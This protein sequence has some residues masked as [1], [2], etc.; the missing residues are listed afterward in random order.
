VGRRVVAFAEVIG[1]EGRH[2]DF[3]VYAMDGAEEIGRGTHQRAVIDLARF[4]ERLAAKF[5]EPT[6]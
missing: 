4:S 5:T 2:V 6:G 3:Q 1:A